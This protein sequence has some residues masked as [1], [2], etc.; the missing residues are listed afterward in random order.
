MVLLRNHDNAQSTESI[1]YKEVQL[2]IGEGIGAYLCE[3]TLPF[4]ELGWV[5]LAA[6]IACHS[7]HQRAPTT[8]TQEAP[9]TKTSLKENHQQQQPR[10][11]LQPPPPPRRRAPPRAPRRHQQD[12][13]TEEQEREQRDE[14]ATESSS[15]SSEDEKEIR[16]RSSSRERLRMPACW[17]VLEADT[18]SG[19][20]RGSCE[21]MERKQYREREARFFVACCTTKRASASL[22]SQH[23][24]CAIQPKTTLLNHL[25]EP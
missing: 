1:T 21:R 2:G 7:Q 14:Q 19:R 10:E 23:Q 15:S 24:A 8:T 4:F 9:N 11:P 12:T 20:A 17:S 18:S 22:L 16:P 5:N 13:R 6:S 3:F 25:I